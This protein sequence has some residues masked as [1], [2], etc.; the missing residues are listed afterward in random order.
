MAR[1]ARAAASVPW[2]RWAVRRGALPWAQAFSSAATRHTIFALSSAQGRAAIAI[3]RLSGPGVDSALQ[4]L[5]PAGAVLPP[6]RTAALASLLGLGGGLLDRALVL[7]F[8]GPRSFTGEDC[9]ELHV[10]GGPAVVRAVLDAL[11]ALGL[12]PAEAGEFSRRAFDAGKLDLTQVEGLADLLAAETESQRRQALLHTTGAA[13]RQHE[14]WRHSLLTCLARL[15]AMIDFGE[16]EGIADDVAAG[17]LP[18]V[19]ALRG[20]LERH[21]ASAVG[22]ELVRSGVRIAIVGPPNA[23]KSSLLNLLAGHD[24][25]IVSPV[26]GTTRDLVQVQLE[27]GGNKVILIDSAGLRQTDC[28][29]EAEGVRRTVAAAQQAH[30]VVHVADAAAGFGAS[31][32]QAQADEQP[33]DSAA[34]PLAPHALQLWV[35]NKTD[36]LQPCAAQAAASQQLWPAA[37]QAAAQQAAC[38]AAAAPASGSGGQLSAAHES[39]QPLLISCRTGQGIEQLLGALQQHVAGLVAQ[40]GDGGMERA[41]PT[42][43]RHMHH[44]SEAVAALQRYEAAASSQLEVAC[45]E[46]RGAA[47]ALGRVT[48]AVDTEEVLGRIFEEFCIGK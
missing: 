29:I 16:D 27:L 33:A 8:P 19:Q 32:G 41:L 20:Q 28:P 36:L 7:R 2:C 31:A 26:A 44:L 42:R 47:R 14:E 21:L 45:E 5:L 1:L 4:R 25:A 24:A 22:G 3:V 6:P 12:R 11:Q 40:G 48:G 13:R 18:Q 9:A 38:D 17:V 37:A 35:L 43:A 34:L 15:E 30:V 39:Q 23:G 46:L 10:H